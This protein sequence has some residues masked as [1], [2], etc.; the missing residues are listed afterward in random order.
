MS[1]DRRSS[2]SP[3]R[4][5]N[6]HPAVAWAPATAASRDNRRSA[7]I[8]IANADTA[9]AAGIAND[10]ADRNR[11]RFPSVRPRSIA[12]AASSDSVTT[13][14][15][16]HATPPNRIATANRFADIANPKSNA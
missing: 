10:P 4:T 6:V 11:N 9:K 5:A 13:I 8:D 14:A 1:N 15:A 3:P 7:T 2:V 16:R 12:T